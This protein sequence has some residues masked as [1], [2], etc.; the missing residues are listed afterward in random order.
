MALQIFKYNRIQFDQLYSDVRN[1][2]TT[3]FLQVGEVFSPA[4]AYGQLLYVILDL[5]RLLFYYIEDSITEL[6][7]MT[8]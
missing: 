3:K 6:N 7:I 5:A 1:F 4:S 8:A 2:M